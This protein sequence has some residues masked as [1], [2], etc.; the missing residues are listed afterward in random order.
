M[1]RVFTAFSGYDSQCMALD[2]VGIDYDLVGWSEIDRYA[3]AAHNA[4]YP[5]YAGRN[6]GDISKIDW[7][8]VPDFDLFNYSSPCQDFSI[9]GRQKGG[10]KGSGTRSSLLWE[11]ERAI[12]Y[13]RPKYL[14]FENVS[15]LVSNKFIRLFND[16]Q[17]T[18]ER[19]GYTNFTQVL[20][21]KDYGVPQNRERVFM[22]SVLNCDKPFY[23]P[24]TIPLRKCLRDVL[25]QEIDR[26]Y[27]IKDTAYEY[28]NKRIGGYC[29][30]N[31][32]DGQGKISANITS[33]YSHNNTGNVIV[34]A[35]LK[36]KAH[37][38]TNRIYSKSGISP[39]LTCCC[40]GNLQPKIL[41]SN[42]GSVKEICNTNNYLQNGDI[43]RR[44]TPKECLRLMDV[45][46]KNIDKLLH[47]GISNSQLYKLAGNS[48][49]VNVIALIFRQLLICNTNK[50]QQLEII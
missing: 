15:A 32:L 24:E 20:N 7:A 14:L 37:E 38:S 26:K 31:G 10:E 39:T 44:L 47:C 2:R 42:K 43:V 36:T 41:Q 34:I 9:A 17:L 49:V 1:I 11:C 45:S 22:V 6:F 12:A 18:L 13:K 4:V 40:G 50:N 19:L 48:I 28:I 25:E 33:S 35:K 29:H 23:F 16:W 30:I 5:Q 3:V 27:L 46:E 8:Q 21:A